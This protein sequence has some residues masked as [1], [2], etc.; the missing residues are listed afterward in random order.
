MSK[1][2]DDGGTRHIKPNKRVE[3]Y[4]VPF[5]KEIEDIMTSHKQKYQIRFFKRLG[6]SGPGWSIP[7]RYQSEIDGLIG[8]S[9]DMTPCVLEGGDTSRVMIS[10]EDKGVQVDESDLIEEATTGKD[11]EGGGGGQTNKSPIGLTRREYVHDVPPEV[12]EF[13]RTFLPSSLLS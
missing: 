3:R 5:A 11:E 13:F 2:S 4:H 8:I 9:N 12:V 7:T 1:D 10:T 6:G